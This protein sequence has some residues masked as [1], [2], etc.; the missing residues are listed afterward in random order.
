MV[1]FVQGIYGYMLGTIYVSRVDS[2]TAI[3]WL[4]YIFHDKRFVLNSTIIVIIIIII[5]V[6]HCHYVPR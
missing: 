2:V 5:I 6:R 1:T 3:L 4:Q